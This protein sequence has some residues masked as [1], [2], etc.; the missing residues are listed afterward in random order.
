MFLAKFLAVSYKFK[1]KL[2]H[3]LPQFKIISIVGKDT[4]MLVVGMSCCLV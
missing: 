2:Y 1:I 3:I 4:L